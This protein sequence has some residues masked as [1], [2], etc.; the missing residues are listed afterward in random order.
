[1][2]DDDQDAGDVDEPT[3]FITGANTGTRKIHYRRNCPR[4]QANAKSVNEKPASVF[5]DGWYDDCE[6]CGP[7]ADVEAGA[8]A[9]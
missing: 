4:L 9:D 2:S 8:G 1:M 7:D 3:I 6:F 5:P